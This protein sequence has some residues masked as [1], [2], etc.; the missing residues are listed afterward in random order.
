M[1]QFFLALFIVFAVG[2]N[3]FVSTDQIAQDV[4]T[5]IQNEFDTRAQFKDY[6]FKVLNLT[7]VKQEGNQYKGLAEVEYEGQTHRIAVN[8]LMDGE[9]YIWEIPAENFNFV[10]NIELEKYQKELDAKLQSIQLEAEDH[11]SYSKP[12]ADTDAV[13]DDA[14]YYSEEDP[15][16]AA[17]EAVAAADIVE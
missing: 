10:R 1:R 3:Y 4:K 2:C 5:Q 8:I 7:V 17:S 11:L 13:A 15:Q 6:H 12:E 9:R 16:S 14:E